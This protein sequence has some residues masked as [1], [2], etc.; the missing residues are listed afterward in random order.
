MLG[1]YTLSGLAMAE[2]IMLNDK[3][4]KQLERLEDTAASNCPGWRMCYRNHRIKDPCQ[5]CKA[6]L[7]FLRG[8]K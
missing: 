4:D 6:V 2:T 3:Q 5:W 1:G 8:V 7:N